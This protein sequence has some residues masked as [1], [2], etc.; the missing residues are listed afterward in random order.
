MLKNKIGYIGSKN[1]ILSWI[2]TNNEEVPI[3][4]EGQLKPS[5]GIKLSTESGKKIVSL[6]PNEI[7]II[8]FQ[9][10]ILPTVKPVDKEQIHEEQSHTLIQSAFLVSKTDYQKEFTLHTGVVTQE[11]L[12]IG[13]TPEVPILRPGKLESF[14]LNIT[15]CTSESKNVALKLMSTS[16]EVLEYQSEE[17][18]I[19]AG[20]A[21]QVPVNVRVPINCKRGFLDIEFVFKENYFS[22]KRQRELTIFAEDAITT[23]SLPNE[24]YSL[25]NSK[26][27]VFF[28]T[29]KECQIY[30]IYDKINNRRIPLRGLIDAVGFPYE[31]QEMTRIPYEINRLTN[32]IELSVTKPSMPQ[33]R[34]IKRIELL[35][36]E[37]VIKVTYVVENNGKTTVKSGGLR[38]VTGQWGANLRTTFST[39]KGIISAF[40]DPQFNLRADYKKILKT[41]NEGWI[42]RKAYRLGTIGIVWDKENFESPI[43]D[44]GAIV[45]LERKF[46]L[47]GNNKKKFNPIYIIIGPENWQ[48]IKRYSDRFYGD[49][50]AITKYQN[51]SQAIQFNLGK[52][53]GDLTQ[54][55]IFIKVNHP[56]Q[57]FLTVKND[58]EREF[59]SELVFESKDIK[60]DPKKITL[61]IEKESEYNRSISTEVLSKDNPTFSYSFSFKSPIVNRKYNSR[62]ITTDSTKPV[63]IV[64][65]SDLN[66]TSPISITNGILSLETSL[67]FKGSPHYLRFKQPDFNFLYS[68]YPIK[69][70]FLW[71]NPFYGGIIFWLMQ[72]RQAFG[73]ASLT[74]CDFMVE[75]AEFEGWKG[76]SFIPT[77]L[78]RNP[79]LKTVSTNFSYLLYP[80]S[81]ILR[82]DF[83][84]RNNS[85]VPIELFS[86]I[87][88]FV[89][90]KL[91]KIRSK[92]PYHSREL[93]FKR[94]VQ[95]IDS[96]VPIDNPWLELEESTS[97]IP[98][99]G[100]IKK[101]NPVIESRRRMNIEAQEKLIEVFEATG[102]LLQGHEE[103]NRTFYI[104]PMDKKDDII[105][106][107]TLK[108]P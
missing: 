51:Q 46:E 90:I 73:L 40:D 44:K 41:V 27:R 45:R 78:G 70:P 11:P 64:L 23:C 32:G 77:N 1:N 13:F 6:L 79:L 85:I 95:M 52:T 43:T 7:K 29:K 59:D 47:T 39:E 60:F 104:I 55:P 94:S 25:E 2:L 33:I 72:I 9:F 87:S 48:S 57:L 14:F 75:R 105:N 91:D 61:K 56:D 88:T 35:I 99:I 58:T 76:I 17:H 54:K 96:T 74:K 89:N 20:S 15:N 50:N 69:E 4:I 103:I 53:K 31:S 80:G 100:F 8:E 107:A 26:I 12:Q 30:K 101:E 62:V 106:Y 71:Y 19:S 21:I 65:P 66:K 36:G 3:L 42:F 108:M 82:V 97:N 92:D 34:L 98:K 5:S 49:I 81:N 37:P 84:V 16:F 68:K 83:N 63:T 102:M 38:T 86:G 18:I 24:H 10:S 22:L 28:R 93:I 67:D